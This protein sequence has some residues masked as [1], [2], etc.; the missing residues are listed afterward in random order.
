VRSHLAAR[1]PDSASKVDANIGRPQVAYRDEISR[2]ARAT[3][4]RPA[5]LHGDVELTIEPRERARA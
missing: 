2:P 1:R 5:A 4:N 3:F